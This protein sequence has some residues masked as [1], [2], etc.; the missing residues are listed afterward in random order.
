MHL[1]L[2]FQIVA[3]EEDREPPS[4]TPRAPRSDGL[5]DELAKHIGSLAFKLALSKEEQQVIID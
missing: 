5:D 4:E 1:I 2:I 3:T